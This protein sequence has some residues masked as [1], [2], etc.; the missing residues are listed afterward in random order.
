[1]QDCGLGP[2]LTSFPGPRE[3]ARLGPGNEAS[4]SP[5]MEFLGLHSAL[6]PTPKN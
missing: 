2:S 6:S 1:M 3:G 5:N 4:P